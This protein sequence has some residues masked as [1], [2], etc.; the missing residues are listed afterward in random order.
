MNEICIHIPSVTR[1]RSIELEVKINGEKR[2]VNYR[3]LTCDWTRGGTDAA[4]RYEHLR[5]FIR[6]HQ[7]D[8]EL[9]QI[10]IPTRDNLVPVMFRQF[11]RGALLPDGAATQSA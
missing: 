4:H 8:W 3:V 1:E 2:L 9:V 5:A 11:Y 6:D 10:G 7:P